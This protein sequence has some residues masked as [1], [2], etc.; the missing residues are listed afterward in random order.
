[1]LGI[2]GTMYTTNTTTIK[3]DGN[4]RIGDIDRENS[5]ISLSKNGGSISGYYKKAQDRSTKGNGKNTDLVIKDESAD[6]ERDAL[7]NCGSETK[8]ISIIGYLSRLVERGYDRNTCIKQTANAFGIDEETML[9]VLKRELLKRRNVKQTK[10]G[11]YY[12]GE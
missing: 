3:A 1:M 10:K 8:D 7:D 5:A 12:L 4:T 2:T 11:D 6:T 9:K